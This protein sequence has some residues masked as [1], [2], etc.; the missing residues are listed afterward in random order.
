[1]I[2]RFEPEQP[3][4]VEILGSTLVNGGFHRLGLVAKV[5]H[6]LASC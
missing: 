1:M 6:V 3:L 4:V 5:V 2:I